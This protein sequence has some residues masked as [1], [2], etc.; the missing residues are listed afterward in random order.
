MYN[1][2][3]IVKND[4]ISNPTLQILEKQYQQV[5]TTLLFQETL[6]IK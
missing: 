6:D 1:N 3:W 2:Y 5:R 4:Y